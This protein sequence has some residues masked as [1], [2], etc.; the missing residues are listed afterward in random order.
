MNR[1]C[2]C[3]SPPWKMVLGTG[4]D[5]LCTTRYVDSFG[6]ELWHRNHGAV[7]RGVAIDDSGNTYEVGHESGSITLRKRDSSGTQL[8]TAQHGADLY[9]CA[10]CSDGVVVGGEAGFGGSTVRKYLSDGTLS[11]SATTDYAVLEIAADLL[12]GVAVLDDPAIIHNRALYAYSASG[13]LLDK[14]YWGFDAGSGNSVYPAGL[15]FGAA[16]DEN[17]GLFANAFSFYRNRTFSSGPTRNGGNVWQAPDG[18]PNA[19]FGTGFGEIF[20]HSTFI[21]PT[22]FPPAFG[23]VFRSYFGT[24]YYFT[25]AA[26]T[27]TFV[28][29]NSND[30]YSDEI[31]GGLGLCGVGN[32]IWTAGSR[33]SRYSRVTP[34][35]PTYPAREW[36]EFPDWQ[37]DHHNTIYSCAANSSY[38]SVL[39]GAIAVI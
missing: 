28:N 37:V 5:L 18:Y 29:T 1:E 30:D 27:G 32:Y 19:G 15:A 22:D 3:C 8:W 23:S 10:I 26:D 2:P 6:T 4:E 39:G 21:S 13:V 14:R 36:G 38:V 16:L 12:N 20:T 11:W 17:T 9:C 25:R 7:V 31:N 35:P 33:L 34:F 24:S